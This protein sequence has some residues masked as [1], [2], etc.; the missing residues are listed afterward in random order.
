MT[1]FQRAQYRVT[2]LVMGLFMFAACSK[3]DSPSTLSGATEFSFTGV[4]VTFTIDQTAFKIQNTDSL[5]YQYNVTA[6]VA[7]FK[8]V[9]GA[10]VKVGTTVQ[11]S[12]ITANNFSQPVIYT[13]IAQDG[14]T[15]RNYTVQ[16]N[17]A[18]VDPKT[19]AWQQLTTDAGWG[20]YHNTTAGFF[21]GKF[22]TFGS[23]L[24]SSNAYT[25]GVVT[26]ADGAT[27]S[28]VALNNNGDSIPA[29]EYSTLVTGFN[30]KLWLLGGHLPGV[31]SAFDFV[32]NK[33]WS[34][35]DA[36]SW[37]A[38][39]PAVATDRWSIRERIS[40]VVFNNKL[41]VIGGNAYPFGGNTNGLG[42]AQRDVW[43]S[44]DGTTWTQVTAAAAFSVRSNPAVFTYKDKI[45]VVGGRNGATYLNEV[46]NSAD[47]ITW[48]QVTTA[49]AFTGRY[50]HKV[51][52]YNNNLY[53]VGGENATDVL[54]DLWISED[55]G[56]NWTKIEP[57]QDVR[58]LPANFA[59]RTQFSLFVNNNAIYIVG[60]LGA[61][62]NNA[63][64]YR[65]DVWKGAL[66]K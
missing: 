37:T 22:Y 16:V 34:S 41:W 29:G 66:V 18:K 38:T 13:V 19:V 28:R 63:Y 54:N 50:G 5:P 60:G 30:N 45:W 24:G 55:D 47:G 62:S 11:Q 56:V 35:S 64:T 49:T 51:V 3:K 7:N 40:A 36:L 25:S 17:V 4:N 43:N 20:N 46:W 26:S 21:N 8:L 6:L 10:T 48:N 15:T 57:G 53:L 1:V 27:W 23:T 39:T 12:G 14:V 42:T 58:A 61:K 44:A 32:T 2:A 33:V 65:N 52:V 59:A 31:G 9:P